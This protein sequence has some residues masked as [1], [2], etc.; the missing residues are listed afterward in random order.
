LSANVQSRTDDIPL[1][2]VQNGIDADEEDIEATW[3]P[4]ESFGIAVGATGMHFSDGNDR[5]RLLATWRQRWYSS[6]RWRIE[7]TL[8]AEASHNSR[9]IA[10][11]YFN[12]RDDHSLWIDAAANYLTWQS[13]GYRFS[14]RFEVSLGSYWQEPNYGQGT[15]TSVS[16]GQ[17]WD[18]GPSLAIRYSIG[19]MVR[20]YDGVREPQF[21]VEAGLVWRF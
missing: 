14:Q 17:N 4:N 18:L 7:T 19:R 10:A 15:M 13:Y 2:A 5:S 3:H 9:G 1:R 21:K 20:P 12:P 16:Y 6:A 8:G 11:S